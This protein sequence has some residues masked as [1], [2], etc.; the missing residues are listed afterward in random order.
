MSRIDGILSCIAV[1]TRDVPIVVPS[2]WAVDPY[3]DARHIPGNASPRR[4]K[5]LASRFV[6]FGFD[7]R[8]V[9]LGVPD[10]DHIE[11]KCKECGN[12]FTR[13]VSCLNRSK[14]NDIECCN[15]GVHADGTRTNPRSEVNRFIDEDEVIRFY[16]DGYSITQTAK[17]FEMNSRRARRIIDDAGA[18][19]DLMSDQLDDEYPT[20]LTGDPWMDEKFVCVECGREFTR[21]QHALT[22][23]FASTGSMRDR[24]GGP[25][26][27]CSPD[28]SMK[29]HNRKSRYKRRKREA[30]G[31]CDTILMD[32]LMERDGGICQICGEEV[33]IND[34]WFDTNGHF[35]IGRFYP[36]VDHIIPLAKGGMTTWDNVQLAHMKC[37]SAKGDK[38]PQE[39]PGQEKIAHDYMRKC[40]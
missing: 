37:N 10:K 16:L 2:K 38:L 12:V 21:H 26:K 6:E 8:F 17:K 40:G 24:R 18:S 28:C 5:G 14:T 30:S 22:T 34:G 9:F 4:K 3:K 36:T 13:N 25:V 32:R 39:S 23:G 11:V 27:Y 15:C 7:K 33:D 35:H 31:K 19:R 29:V 20:E 1:E